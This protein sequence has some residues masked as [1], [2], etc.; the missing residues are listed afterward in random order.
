M[1]HFHVPSSPSSVSGVSYSPGK[2]RTSHRVAP[3]PIKAFTPPPPVI[4]EDR[5]IGKKQIRDSSLESDPGQREVGIFLC[6]VKEEVEIISV[7]EQSTRFFKQR[8]ISTSSKALPV[9]E[10]QDNTHRKEV[11][12]P[13]T[14]P[15]NKHKQNKEFCPRFS[16]SEQVFPF[17]EFLDCQ[18]KAECIKPRLIINFHL[19]LKNGMMSLPLL[20]RCCRYP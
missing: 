7:S 9:L 8:T 11:S 6:C 4:Y 1:F 2:H 14:D 3:W 20:M 13:G 15:H 5:G 10:L 17:L 18:L 12:G 19:L 16:L